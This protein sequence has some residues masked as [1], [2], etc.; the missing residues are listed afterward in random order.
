M[1]DKKSRRVKVLLKK[2]RKNPEKMSAEEIKELDLL[3]EEYLSE[4]TMRYLRIA[5]FFQII[6]FICLAIRVL[7]NLF[8]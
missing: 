3:M 1:K 6:T 5:L 8:N 7:A 2:E 4:Q